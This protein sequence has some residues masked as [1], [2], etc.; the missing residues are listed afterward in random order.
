MQQ[1]TAI[2]TQPHRAQPAML[3]PLNW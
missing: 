2:L 3:S 1:I